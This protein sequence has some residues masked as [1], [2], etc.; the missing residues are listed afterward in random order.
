M[1]DKIKILIVDDH[2]VVREGLSAW[3]DSEP[4]L[5]LIGEAADGEAGVTETLRLQPDIVLMDLAMPKM[6][7]ITAIKEIT[8]NKPNIR[9]L[10]ITSFSEQDQAVKAIK[11]GSL[12]FMMKD[13]SPTEMLQAIRSVSEGNPWLSPSLTRALIQNSRDLKS[14]GEPIDPLTKREIE[15][16][17]LIAQGLSD[18][19]IA[20]ALTVSKTTVRYHVTNILTKLQLENRTQAALFAIRKKLVSI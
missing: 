3:I 18:Q 19:D 11:A 20:T 1:A 13:A 12:G 15:V 4:D 14:V 2:A 5:I 7:G 9:I 6:D 10:V 17:K 16:L 8:Q